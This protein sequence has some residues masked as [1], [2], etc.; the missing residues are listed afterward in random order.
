M[1]VDPPHS[2]NMTT[3]TSGHFRDT[4]EGIAFLK[5]EIANKRSQNFPKTHIISKESFQNGCR[6]QQDS[7]LSVGKHKGPI[8]KRVR[9][10]ISPYMQFFFFGG[11]FSHS[12]HKSNASRNSIIIRWVLLPLIMITEHYYRTIL[13]NPLEIQINAN[14]L[15]KLNSFVKH[16]VLPLIWNLHETIVPCII[17]SFCV[18]HSRAPVESTIFDDGYISACSEIPGSVIQALGGRPRMRS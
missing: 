11:Y 2:L 3:T 13:Q 15:S 9:I 5:E 1:F 7:G 16:V 17:V 8:L 4:I 18:M 14:M 6:H 10:L 12:L